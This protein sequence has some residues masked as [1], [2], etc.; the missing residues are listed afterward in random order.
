MKNSKILKPLVLIL[1]SLAITACGG[2]GGEEKDDERT[3]PAPSDLAENA[4][5]APSSTPVFNLSGVVTLMEY[6]QVVDQKEV[7]NSS[8]T[9]GS[10][11]ASLKS[12]STLSIIGNSNLLG[13][14]EDG[15]TVFPVSNIEPL[16]V[17]YTILS[18]DNN[19]LYIAINSDSYDNSSIASSI[20]INGYDLRSPLIGPTLTSTIPLTP[21]EFEAMYPNGSWLFGYGNDDSTCAG[22]L[23][24]DQTCLETL[25]IW[26]DSETRHQYNLKPILESLQATILNDYVSCSLVA[27]DRLNG[28]IDCVGG[29][30]VIDAELNFLYQSFPIQLR[31]AKF[32]P[33]DTYESELDAYEEIRSGLKPLQFDDAG[34]L[35]SVTRHYDSNNVSYREELT[36]ITPTHSLEQV[37]SLDSIDVDSFLAMANGDIAANLSGSNNGIFLIQDGDIIKVD[38]SYTFKSD[39]GST[40]IIDGYLVEPRDDGG[41]ARTPLSWD[42]RSLNEFYLDDEGFLFGC[43][44]DKGY[45]RVLPFDDHVSIPSEDYS[46]DIGIISQGHHVREMEIGIGNLGTT[47]II[48]ITRLSD[49]LIYNIFE[50]ED[51]TNA[52][53][54]NITNIAYG[55]NKVI[56]SADRTTSP[57]GT[58][59]GE[60]D[61]QKLSRGL[62]PDEYMTL[63]DVNSSTAASNTVRKITPLPIIEPTSTASAPKISEVYFNDT[64]HSHIG[65]EFSE[66]MDKASV[67]DS[68]SLQESQI[69]VEYIPF[70]GYKK[71]YLLADTDGLEDNNSDGTVDS[72]DYKAYQAGKNY[73]VVFDINTAMDV[74]GR[75]MS[76]NTS[77]N[78]NHAL[79]FAPRSAFYAAYSTELNSHAAK[80][81][82]SAGSLVDPYSDS[83]NYRA[84]WNLSPGSFY[85]SRAYKVIQL[86]E[87]LD[88]DDRPLA[89][90]NY[91]IELTIDC[92]SGDYGLG[93]R[94]ADITATDSYFSYYW[95]SESEV[96]GFSWGCSR[97]QGSIY[98]SGYSDQSTSTLL[99]EGVKQIRID[100]F[101]STMNFY[102]FN[103]DSNSYESLLYSDDAPTIDG[104]AD[105]WLAS[106]GSEHQTL[107]NLRITHLTKDGSGN[108]VEGDVFAETDFEDLIDPFG[109]FSSM[110]IPATNEL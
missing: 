18:P 39:T 25:D 35:Y 93:L 65:F 42:G 31:T 104:I 20:Y 101:D 51:Y 77:P 80:L 52:D 95:S 4:V 49:G 70:W 88:A 41:F 91:R 96:K 2:K 26:V 68:L 3:Q 36:K 29:S 40:L 74:S 103:I 23:T 81:R 57:V 63:T 110:R 60:I 61:I 102:V 89:R 32:K 72:N 10:Q 97:M 106:N 75:L 47:E 43:L 85:A 98:S 105:L 30:E 9:L 45:V 19:R 79:T 8:F 90:A 78:S 99:A 82:K 37:I 48:E 6:D 84:Y 16:L 64:E 27:I 87:S 33:R 21:S 62:T 46:C 24:T 69:D 73:D 44:R 55:A 12:K 50:E 83:N 53:R 5:L 59:L 11:T 38:D 1:S 109:A 58:I 108:L 107:D 34:N 67:I 86:T 28:D 100:I 71:L 17:D 13:I 92:H 94:D 54:Y 56:F 15:N 22:V 14:D 76:T 66:F 7:T